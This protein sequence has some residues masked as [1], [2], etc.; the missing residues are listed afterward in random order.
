MWTTQIVANYKN[1]D[2]QVLTVNAVAEVALPAPDI[3]KVPKAERIFLQAFSG[4]GGNIVIGRT[5][6]D[7]NGATGCYELPSGANMWLPAKDYQNWVARGTAAGQK[8]FVTYMSGV[9]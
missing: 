4:N 3:T 2:L 7:A 6:V 8:L 9:E 1:Q 5:G